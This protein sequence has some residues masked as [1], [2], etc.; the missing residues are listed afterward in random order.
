MQEFVFRDILKMRGERVT[1]FSHLLEALRAGCPPHAGIALG[2]DRLVALICSSRF[3]TKMSLRD[4]IA[5]PK[6]GKGEDL[7]MKSPA[8]LS[9][10]VLDTYHLKLRG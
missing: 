8:P 5:F 6:S 3:E 1:E 9:E 4:V 7:M 2:L 10:E